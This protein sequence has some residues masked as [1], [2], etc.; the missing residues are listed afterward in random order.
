MSAI[1]ERK[2]FQFGPF[3][4]D[5]RDRLLLLEG[6]VIPLTPKAADTLYVLI[7]QSGHVVDRE[8]LLKTVW[9]D[10]FVEESSLT[11]NISQLRKA[12]GEDEAH[13][14]IET[15][16]KRGYRFVAEVRLVT[17]QPAVVAEADASR[18]TGQSNAKRPLAWSSP[19]LLFLAASVL[20]AVSIGFPR[21]LNLLQQDGRLVETPFTTLP[22][23]E[24]EPQFSPDG[25]QLAFV[26][27]GRNEKHYG[28]YVQPLQG[29]D[30][31]PVVSDSADEGSP[32]WSPD[33]REIAFIRYSA[34]DKNG[35][36][37]INVQN[38]SE[39]KVAPIV[40]GERVYDRKLDW[41]PDGKTIAFI[42][43]L[44]A[45]DP[46]HIDVVQ[47]DTGARRTLTHPP[48]NSVGDTSP[49]FSRNGG[50]IAFKRT[51]VSGVNDIYIVSAAGGE[52]RRLTR[53]NRYVSGL[54]WSEDG[55]EIVFASDREGGRRLWKIP[56]S[57]GTPKAIPAATGAT[58]LA[59]ARHGHRLAYSYWFAD[60]NIWGMEVSAGR[61]LRGPEKL[62][63]STRAE[64][65][66]QY[67]PDHSRIA[68]RSD[69]SGATEIWVA[70]ASGGHATRVTS[71]NGPL[72]GS[73]R[74]SP[75][76]K[77][78]A[79]DSRPEGTSD[80]YVVGARGGSPRRVTTGPA[81]NVLPSWSQDGKW[82]YFASN[83]T[84]SWELWKL[85]TDQSGTPVQLTRSGGFS[86]FESL[87][88]AYVYYAKGPNTPGLWRRPTGE[89]KEEL[90]VPQLKAGLWGCWGVAKN[91]IYFV[92]PDAA[93][94]A[95]IRLVDPIT[96]KISTITTLP[97]KP[98]FSDSGFAVS[99]DGSRF[100]F[101][102]TDHSGSD[103]T[104][105]NDFR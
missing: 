30:A 6:Q 78:L 82:I 44:S 2:I 86:A 83:R 77:Y 38:K 5:E 27:N 52:P 67:S 29:G 7:T 20:I 35:I 42:D 53:E 62:I 57:G 11:R 9:P 98:P 87:D 3:R 54:D 1:P 39:R 93:E 60:T 103:I 71:F 8:D 90:V 16:P 64:T 12:L 4:F 10:T 79:F 102:Q 84:G 43:N 74:W 46:L 40:R 49:V 24:F 41:S 34:G 97:A 21:I 85:A 63:A 89:G 26:W 72:T 92:D 22:G 95:A 94:G 91:G 104:L 61:L 81:D 33:G 15:I 80:I 99:R 48:A 69:Q 55:K 36:Y 17:T 51:T 14:Y 32:C 65:S 59:V 50:E 101:T 58:F 68:Y 66:A 100:L 45:E 75:D 56:A 73:P 31:V 25:N 23:G 70:D 76:G 47:A 28:I 19:G 13:P 37:I 96:M 105:V 18:L 88:G